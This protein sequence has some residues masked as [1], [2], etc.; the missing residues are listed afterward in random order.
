[1]PKSHPLGRARIRALPADLRSAP[2]AV[3]ESGARATL[4]RSGP[5]P[6]IGP[7]QDKTEFDRRACGRRPSLVWAD[8]PAIAWAPP[9]SI[10]TVEAKKAD[11]VP[12]A[13]V[14]IEPMAVSYPAHADVRS[15]EPHGRG[16]GTAT[17]S[18]TAQIGSSTGSRPTWS[19]MP[20][21][22]NTPKLSGGRHTERSGRQRAK[23]GTAASSSCL[24]VRSATRVLDQK[25]CM[26]VGSSF[27]A[28]SFVWSNQV[29]RAA[30]A[31]RMDLATGRSELAALGTMTASP[32]RS[33][34]L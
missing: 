15:R 28:A 20:A 2:N 10:V 8:P 19:S 29:L 24:R 25:V 7:T 34:R 32:V 22:S 5:D 18:S 14:A 9:A 21:G 11:V 17:L 4:K 30:S 12:M 26:S 3:G 6:Y 33:D 23:Y 1:M 13:M 16:P 27:H 31:A